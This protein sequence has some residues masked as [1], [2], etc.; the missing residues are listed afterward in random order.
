[1]VLFL[2]T[3]FSVASND[4]RKTCCDI[5]HVMFTCFLW[6]AQMLTVMFCMKVVHPQTVTGWPSMNLEGSSL[7]SSL[8]SQYPPLRNG[9]WWKPGQY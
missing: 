3:W 4:L 7:S 5:L 2:S 9:T 1:M 6:S 8:P